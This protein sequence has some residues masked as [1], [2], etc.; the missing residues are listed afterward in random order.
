M[1]LVLTESQEIYTI[2]KLFNPFWF[3]CSDKFKRMALE[4][5]RICPECRS[6]NVWH[7]YERIV[8]YDEN[9]EVFG[10]KDWCDNPYSAYECQ[11]CGFNDF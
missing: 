8:M 11:E 6:K 2:G 4:H 9:G 1:S 3:L 7:Y 10:Y 5:F